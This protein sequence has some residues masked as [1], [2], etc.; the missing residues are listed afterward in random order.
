MAER[1]SD[2]A[3]KDI[4]QLAIAR[5]RTAVMSVGQLVEDDMQRA[6]LLT[7]VALDLIKGAA[8]NMAEATGNSEPDEL[9]FVVGN[10][11]MN[12]GGAK[13]VTDMVRVQKR[14]KPGTP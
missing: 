9:A 3:M 7:S 4:S 1:L 10:L 14:A 6:A 12:L 5:V 11:L 13:L 8:V 2:Q